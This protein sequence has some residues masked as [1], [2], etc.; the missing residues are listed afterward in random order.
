MNDKLKVIHFNTYDVGG[1][2]EDFTFDFL[3]NDSLFDACLLVKSKKSSSEKVVELPLNFF[4]R[5]LIQ[6]DKILWK[7][8]VQK[9]I[10]QIFSISEELNFTYDKISRIKEYQ[11]ADIVHLHNIHGGYFDL[12]AL[13]SI[14]KDKP[15]VWSFHDMWAMTGGEAYTFE[16]ENFKKGIATTPYDHLHP[17]NGPLI[18]RRQHHMEKKR[19]VFKKIAKRL[20]IIPGSTWLAECARSSYVFNSNFYV[21]VIH[22]S[23]DI[24]IYK[25]NNQRIWHIPR[26]LIINTT[27]PYKGGALFKEILPIFKGLYDLHVIGNKLTSTCCAREIIYHPYLN[28]QEL[29]QL[30]NGVDIL[31]FPSKA[32][33]FSLTV[34]A[35][36]SCG[37]CVL[38]AAS[39]G[40]KEQLMD[41]NGVLFEYNDVP[42]IL[43]ALKNSI[44]NLTETRAIGQRASMTVN[45]KYNT[46]I[47]Y[48]KYNHLYNNIVK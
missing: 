27:N 10:K 45:A 7:I 18:D 11:T 17:L 36:M 30:F 22:E 37:V 41:N 40:I 12:S 13:V 23:I 48:E 14:A 47:M 24:S 35:A 2:A 21:D 3:L 32:E 33:N 19:R 34:L 31:I 1:G 4:D 43:I 26:I 20:Y 5:I 28:K 9:T 6:V 29:S 46:K 42:G 16:N 44:E 25:N 15:I 38:G 8:G 39:G